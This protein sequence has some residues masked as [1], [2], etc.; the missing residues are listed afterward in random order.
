MAVDLSGNIRVRAQAAG[1]RRENREGRKEWVGKWVKNSR[2]GTENLCVFFLNLCM[3]KVSPLWQTF[4]IRTPFS[5]TGPWHVWLDTIPY[6]HRQ[7]MIYIITY[8]ITYIITYMI[9]YNITYM[10]TYIITYMSVCL[11]TSDH[12]YDDKYDHIYVRVSVDKWWHIYLYAY[13]MTCM[14][15]HTSLFSS[16]T[17]D[18]YHHKYDH[19]HVRV[20]I[21][22]WWHI[23]LYAYCRTCM[24]GYNSLCL[25]IRIMYTCVCLSTWVTW[26]F[27]IR[28][29]Y[30]W[31]G[32]D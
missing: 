16:T 10:L 14:T 17:D 30:I 21:D 31:G 19:I 23:H 3:T 18:I 25:H 2:T 11:S 13:C 20:P 5:W 7:V 27:V 24:T 8:M 1:C 9:T 12:I 6:S 32:Y 15:W 29:L 4:G 28:L 22:K 26:G